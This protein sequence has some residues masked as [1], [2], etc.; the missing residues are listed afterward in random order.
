MAQK[1]DIG[2]RFKTHYENRWR[3]M[4]PRRTYTI[5]RIDGRAFH[6]YT[7]GCERPFDFEL[8]RCFQQTALKMCGSLSG[9]QFAYGQSDE[10]S[11]LLTD[12]AT[13]HTQAWFDGNLQKIVSIT[14]SEFTMWFNVQ[15][16]FSRRDAM[17][18]ARAF[19][20]PDP[21]EVAN[22]F[23]WRQQDATRNSIQM[24]AQALYS[25]KE[26]HEKNTDDMQEMLFAKGVNWNDY[27]IV[28]KRGT[29]ILKKAVGSTT[30]TYT[31]KRTNEERT[32]EIPP[33]DAWAVDTETP[34][35]TKDRAYLESVI[36]RVA[37]SRSSPTE[38]RDGE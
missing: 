2:E 15:V 21:E 37:L 30:K 34:I 16:P 8:I 38:G 23:I 12:F 5:I 26:L 31:D 35:F 28:A 17:F 1:D 18:D 9:C 10:F 22:Y 13:I 4:L 7:R 29:G 32:V 19:I 3:F 14:A 25:P 6:T 36:P 11:F 24:A 20:V 27:P 33:H